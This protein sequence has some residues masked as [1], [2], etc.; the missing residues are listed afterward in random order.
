MWFCSFFC[1]STS[2]MFVA[3]DTTLYLVNEAPLSVIRQSDWLLCAYA[4]I[5]YRQLII[6]FIV[7]TIVPYFV[8]F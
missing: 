1:A 6:Y 8:Q 5:A 7:W 2:L 4:V 3:G